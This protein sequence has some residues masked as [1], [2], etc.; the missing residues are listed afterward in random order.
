MAG[1]PAEWERY[2]RWNGAIAEVVYSRGQAGL[3]VYL[4][5]EDSVLASIRD[6]AE[7]E[8]TDV[9]SA[10][11]QTLIGTLVFTDGANSVLRGHLPLIAQLLDSPLPFL[12]CRCERGPPLGATPETR[13]V[14]R[15]IVEPRW[16]ALLSF[17]R[18]LLRTPAAQ[19]CSGRRTRRPPDAEVSSL[20]RAGWAC[21][22]PYPPCAVDRGDVLWQE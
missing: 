20:P 8:A 13:H 17:Y 12:S 19:R 4:D 16:A 14:P 9:S 6:A 7:P 3:P 15:E 18:L 5:L 21:L 10:L 1:S 22:L 2:E 11:I